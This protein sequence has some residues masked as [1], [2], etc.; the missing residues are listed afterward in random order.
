M[1]A[2][3][4]S[5]AAASAPPALGGAALLHRSVERAL[6]DACLSGVLNLS[7]RK[8]KDFPRSTA[9]FDLSDVTEADLSR[10]RLSEVPLDVC[11]Y[12]SMETL[13]LYHNCIKSIP[14][15][16]GNLQVLTYLN[17]SRN[18]LG[19]LPVHVCKLP[20]L[21]VLV[22][23]NNKI[24]SLPPDIGQLCSLLELDVSCN[25][26]EVLPPEMGSLSLLRELNVRRN[27]LTCLP[28]ELSRLPL[29]SLDFACNRVTE[30]PLCYRRLRGLQV[31]QL[32]NNPLRLPPAQVCVK[33]K[34][35]IMKFL[36][37]EACRI[38]G[39]YEPFETPE[40]LK[41][42]IPKRFVDSCVED[43]V[44]ERSWRPDSGIVSDSSDKRFET[45]EEPCADSPKKSST[46]DP[47][48]ALLPAPYS[49]SVVVEEE[50]E[51]QPPLVNGSA[52]G[53]RHE[54]DRAASA[55]EAAGVPVKEPPPA[56]LP[57]HVTGR[58]EATSNSREPPAMEP[59][60]SGAVQWEGASSG[61][62][63][64]ADAH[65]KLAKMD[66]I[67]EGEPQAS[68]DNGGDR[69]SPSSQHAMAAG[70]G[71]AYST[72]AASNGPSGAR[73]SSS[74]PP[75]QE[76]AASH[77]GDW[78]P[79]G[80]KPRSAARSLACSLA[81]PPA[82]L[83]SADAPPPASAPPQPPAP[84][85][86]AVAA[87]ARVNGHGSPRRPPPPQRPQNGAEGGA[88]HPATATPTSDS[89]AFSLQK[90]RLHPLIPENPNFTVRRKMEQMKE[91]IKLIEQLRENIESRLNR[92]LP[93]DMGSALMDG[94]MLCNLANHVRPRS[95]PII[96]EPSPAVPQLSMTKCRKN[97]E[98]FLNACKR[99]G[100]P[101]SA[102]CSPYELTQGN[103][104]AI[105]VTV[106]AL[107]EQAEP[108][109]LGADADAALVAIPL[110]G[111]RPVHELV[112]FCLF[113]LLAML[114][115]LYALHGVS[116]F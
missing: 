69:A 80:L 25:E 19:S 23:S 116:L 6:E 103:L 54:H 79:F 56:A 12:V 66:S 29:V 41:R 97:V 48:P 63:S 67:P 112:G 4:A 104:S 81:R 83:K 106:S 51:K 21:K 1:A 52:P 18:Q 31:I 37:V 58:T 95:V 50:E 36:T 86:T 3:A 38:E 20:M 53:A 100:V 9:S 10:N 15:P 2:A 96:Y 99:I 17:L 24:G 77:S 44:R 7:G 78:H 16:L 108:R 102:L 91:E 8:L 110:M 40:Q 42:P 39:R 55:R 43:S 72:A 111:R 59:H 27:R 82:L 35:H 61:E 88:P 11:H 113:Y 64:G 14:D 68:G 105:H 5:T 33:G 90:S 46:S 13:Y 62:Q 107:L 115:L 93:L 94:V 28:D 49:S 30:I 74:S 65:R 71:G 75:A 34:V 101:K 45:E 26:L 98:S 89:Q 22:L 85:C 109:P 47:A 60:R 32:D 57:G 114:M 73:A 76:R 87:G 70:Q 92:C 84:P